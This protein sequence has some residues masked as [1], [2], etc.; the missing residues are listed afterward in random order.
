MRLTGKGYDAE[1]IELALA[2]EARVLEVYRTDSGWED[3]QEA[4]D[5]SRDEAWFADS[6]IGLQ[7][8]DSWN[9]KWY[10]G[11]FDYDPVKELTSGRNPLLAMYGQVDTIVDGTKSIGLLD[12]MRDDARREISTQELPGVGHD[13][14]GRKAAWPALYWLTLERWMREHQLVR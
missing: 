11:L 14:G 6:Q 9:W 7:P 10:A 8:R 1:A 4:V 13:L 12:A 5:A 2:L 3:V